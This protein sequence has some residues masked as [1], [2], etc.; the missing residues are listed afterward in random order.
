M[1]TAYEMAALRKD[2][3]QQQVIKDFRIHLFLLQ[4]PAIVSHYYSSAANNT[5]ARILIATRSCRAGNMES[6]ISPV[7]HSVSANCIVW[8][9]QLLLHPSP[10]IS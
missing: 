6:T 8:F 1:G 4:T 9:F 10:G 2:L 3:R 7:A 5:A